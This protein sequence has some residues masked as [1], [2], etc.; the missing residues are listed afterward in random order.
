MKKVLLIGID[1]KLIDFNNLPQDI[2]IE[3]IRR[4]AIQA[5]QKLSELGYEIYNC[6]TDLGET[7][8]STILEFLNN[9][10]FDCIMI[11]AGIRMINAHLFL[12]EKIINVIHSNAAQSKICFNT[13]PSD[14]YEA[15]LRWI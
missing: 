4:E 10:R 5:N 1:P 3:L 8:E 14:S 6:F 15:V 7:A 2:D 13:R 12:L 9:N 11:G